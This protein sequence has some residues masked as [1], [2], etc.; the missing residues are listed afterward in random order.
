M[1]ASNLFRESLNRLRRNIDQNRTQ[2]GPL[3][4]V[5]LE[6]IT[7]PD[8]TGFEIRADALTKDGSVARSS[9]YS[10]APLNTQYRTQMIS[11]FR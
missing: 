5:I 7:F 1:A 3:E 10:S 9:N 2:I 6:S 11:L 4:R 8:Q